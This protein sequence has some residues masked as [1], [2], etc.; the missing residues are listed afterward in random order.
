AIAQMATLKMSVSAIARE[1]AVDR[2]TVRSF[3][4]LGTP[5]ERH[6]RAEGPSLLDP[7]KE[8]IRARLAQYPLSSVRLLEEIRQKGYSGGY[9]LVKRFVY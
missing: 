6:A 8:H 5:G 1:L 2:K 7:Y 3:L 9:D 4:Q